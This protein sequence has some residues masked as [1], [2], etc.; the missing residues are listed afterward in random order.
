M[1]V[2][3][4]V[5][6]MSLNMSDATW[7]DINST[8]PQFQDM[9][10][11]SQ[12]DME[13]RYSPEKVYVDRY[14]TPIIY[15]IGFPGNIVS[16][17]VWIQRRMRHSSGCYLAALALDD[18]IFLVLHVMFE[19]HT[20][21]HIPTLDVPGLCEIYPVFYIATQYLSPLLVLGFT[22]ERYISIC[23][24]FKREKFCTTRRAKIVIAFLATLSLCMS[25]IQGYFYQY[26]TNV[27][28]CD[29]RQEVSQGGAINFFVVW[30]MCIEMFVFLLVPL[31]V[32]LLNVLVIREMRKLSRVETH[33]LHGKQ[34]R[35]SATTVMLLAVSFYQ[36]VTT[37]PVTIVYALYFVFPTGEPTVRDSMMLR[38]PTWRR[39]FTYMFVQIVIKEYGTTHY[40]INILIYL[41]TGK[42]FRNELKKLLCNNACAKL[43]MKVPKTEYSSLRSTQ[44]TSL[45]GTSQWVSVN[46]NTDKDKGNG[47]AGQETNV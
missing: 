25:S 9:L 13:L 11:T 8:D 46:G 15:A 14:V 38:D 32:L 40:A 35:T 27:S 16:F 36:I 10:F 22:V 12:L 4:T 47:G 43:V 6:V 17:I 20:V 24:P 42:M 23:H 21:W 5:S 2:T 33:K 3:S 18:L 28:E 45:R 31:N 30:N 7:S 29:L 37:L 1:D 34:Q 19:M 26:N 44:R 39:Y 41:I